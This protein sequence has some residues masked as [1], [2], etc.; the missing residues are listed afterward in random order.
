MRVTDSLSSKRPPQNI[1]EKYKVEKQDNLSASSVAVI[2]TAPTPT[3]IEWAVFAPIAHQEF[4][5]LGSFNFNLKSQV[6]N[7]PLVYYWVE[8]F[9]ISAASTFRFG[10]DWLRSIFFFFIQFWHRWVFYKLQSCCLPRYI[11]LTQFNLICSSFSP[12]F[13]LWII[14]YWSF[15]FPFLFLVVLT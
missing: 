9:I 12:F 3:W 1:D 7:S 5:V 14:M 10:F 6:V 2:A 15:S 8:V 11:T 13:S 4:G